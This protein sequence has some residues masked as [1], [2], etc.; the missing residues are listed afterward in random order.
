MKNVSSISAAQE[1]QGSVFLHALQEL[2]VLTNLRLVV[3]ES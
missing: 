3:P 2:S 1:P